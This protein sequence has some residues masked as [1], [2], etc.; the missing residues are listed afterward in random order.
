MVVKRLFSRKETP[1]PPPPAAL[2]SG[3]RVYAIGD[4]H[5]RDDLLEALLAKI[6][7][8]D[9]GRSRAETQIIFLGDLP[10]R[11]PTSRQVIE[12]A[13]ALADAR[14]DTVF[15]KG[16]HEELLIRVWDGD[17]QTASTFHRAGGRET[18]MSYGVTAEQ[19]D[20]WDLGDVT[21]ATGRVVPK[22]HIDF[23]RSFRPAYRLGDYFFAH[24]GVRPG[25]ALDDQEEK[26]L[27][28]IR[29]EF[30]ESTADFGAVVVHGH[31]IRDDVEERANRIG[32]DTGAYASGRLTAVGLE[33]TER[34]YLAT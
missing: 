12:R 3:K 1:A 13:M 11:G 31:T 34:W 28:W 33:G 23:L 30:I 9:A 21:E 8:D 27:R 18:L 19:Y 26:D 29:A 14:P 10:D 25:I 17:R 6:D 15:L 24:A 16:N 4:I 7:A 5:G 32:I 20:G 22:A 2:P